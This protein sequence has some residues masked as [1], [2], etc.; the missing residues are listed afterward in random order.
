MQC[1]TVMKRPKLVRQNAVYKPVQLD[2]IN[3]DIQYGGGKQ[4][5]VS[6]GCSKRGGRPR[7]KSRSTAY[8]AKSR[9]KSRARSKSK[10][11]K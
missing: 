10:N 8:R 5:K 1:L 6:C 7:G 3:K 11:K 2:P 9:S 4:R